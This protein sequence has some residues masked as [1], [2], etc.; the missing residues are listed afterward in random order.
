MNKN[1]LFNEIKKTALLKG[2]F[3][4]RS[5]QSATEYFDKYL[6]ESSPSLLKSLVP[7][8][9]TLIPSDTEILAGLEM[10]GIPLAVALSLDSNIPCVFVRKKAKEYGTKKITEGCSVQNKKVCVVED[11]IT[12]GGQVMAS[13]QMMRKE[14]ALIKNVI[15][16]IYRGE[17]K[18]LEK[19]QEYGLKLH[20]LFKWTT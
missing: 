10:G 11:V 15:C 18:P 14:G 9:K 17:Q 19:L 2:H 6:F 5:G 13:A 20:Y 3:V 12:T 4:L 8:L 7:H 16:V 1:T